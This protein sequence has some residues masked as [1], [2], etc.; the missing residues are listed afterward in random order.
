MP[1]LS[2]FIAFASVSAAIQAALA[3][4]KL[5]TYVTGGQYT[6]RYVRVRFKLQATNATTRVKLISAKLTIDLP[7]VNQSFLNEAVSAGGR[8]FYLTGFKKVKSV[9]MTTVGTS[10]L[11]PRIS[12][13]SAL[14][15]SFDI[16]M[17]D[18]DGTAQAGSCNI[19]CQG[20]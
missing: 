5:K 6:G 3:A 2:K 16:Q 11:M 13:Q 9:V 14:P 4:A 20:Y 1:F 7:D 10:N 12:D 18:T 15:N 8:T 19:F 17:F